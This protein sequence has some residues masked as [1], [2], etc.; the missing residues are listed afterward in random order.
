VRASKIQ[1]SVPRAVQIFPANIIRRKRIA[2]RP[3]NRAIAHIE[4]LNDVYRLQAMDGIARLNIKQIIQD[5]Q[6]AYLGKI[7]DPLFPGQFAAIGM[8]RVQVDP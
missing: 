7:S 3:A 6:T 5:E 4:R 2:I 1:R 8:H